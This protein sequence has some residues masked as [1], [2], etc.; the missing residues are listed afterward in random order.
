MANQQ[1]QCPAFRTSIGGQALIEGIMMRGP[2]KQAIAV[3]TA[4][5]ITVKEDEL[6]FIKD[7]YPILGWP[8]IRGTVNFL[9]SMVNGVKA[10]T[11]SAEQ[12]PEEEQ[13]EPGKL[14]KWIMEHFSSET[15]DKLIIGIAVVLGI[16]LAVGLFIILPTVLVGFLDGVLQSRV[17]RNL[18]EGVVRIAIFLGYMFLATKLK[19]IKRVWM[20]HGAE[21]KTIFC[22]EHGLELTVENCRKQ[23]RF[24]PRCGTSFIFIVMIVSILVYSVFSWSNMLV[25]MLIRILLLPVV[26]GISYE[27]IKWAGRSD[28]WATRI[29]SAPGKALQHL[30]TA[31]PDDSMLEVAIA[32]M[33]RVIPETAGE[34]AW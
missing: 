11:Y 27:I 13:E 2:R 12:Q 32:A 3:R 23:S 28:N 21:H 33:K 6:K 17:L 4:E 31:E 20:Y 26:V 9:G 18:L 1:K 10:L 8:L 22:Y 30:T 7:R 5:G 16:A 34:D 19:E 15:A 24:H 14:D 29:A 25:R